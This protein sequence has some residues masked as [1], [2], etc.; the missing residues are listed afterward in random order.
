[1]RNF[2]RNSILLVL[3]PLFLFGCGDI[4]SGRNKDEIPLYGKGGV[5][6]AREKKA[7]ALFVEEA[8]KEAG[9][10]EAA[11]KKYLKA[12]FGAFRYG[13]FKGAIKKF[14]QAWLI[15]P[16]NADVFWGF[17]NVLG[18]GGEID[19]AIVMLKKAVEISPSHYKAVADLAYA[20]QQK[21]YRV[22]KSPEKK[23]Y[24]LDLSDKTFV[25]ANNI[26]PGYELCYSNWAVTLYLQGRYKESW[27]KIISAR[28]LGGKSLDQKFIKDLSYVMPEPKK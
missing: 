17:G 7:D 21:S 10:G 1:M 28:K 22:A 20:Y 11:L 4:L 6:S 5:R 2:L 26:N 3:V 23:S 27:D 12:G 25:Q 13:D 14:N 16:N 15:A 9:S 24:Y 8:I 19:E 18:A